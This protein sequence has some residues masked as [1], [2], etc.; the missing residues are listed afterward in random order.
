MND[1][2]KKNRRIL[3]RISSQF[4]KEENLK[5]RRQKRKKEKEN[6]LIQK[7]WKRSLQAFI[8]TLL[9]C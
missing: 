5:K 1:P 8:T 4:V 3:Q 6:R 9:S 2:K 7:Q